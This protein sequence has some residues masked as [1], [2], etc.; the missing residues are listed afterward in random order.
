M[1]DPTTELAKEFLE[2]YGYCIRKVT[3]FVKN[4]KLKGTPSDI[5]IIAVKS[6]KTNFI[7]L[8][9]DKQIIAEVKNWP[10]YDKQTFDH[11]YDDKFKYIN[12]H[13]ISRSQLKDYF[14]SSKFDRI[15]FCHST[16]PEIFNYAFKKKVKI[17]TSGFIIKQLINFDKKQKKDSFY[18]EWYNLSLINTL[19]DYL[20][21]S[22]E[23]ND[24]LLLEDL[25]DI[26]FKKNPRI[27]KKFY[28]LNLKYFK[29]INK[30]FND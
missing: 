30:K 9:L 18:P 28:N 12:N 8:V 17:I 29:K 6:K 26:D 11:I 22:Y 19:L 1:A 5:D 3:K 25:I 27:L 16:T 20:V 21:H 14:S 13:D 23:F 2:V 7:K 24:K 4:K 10:V 15:L